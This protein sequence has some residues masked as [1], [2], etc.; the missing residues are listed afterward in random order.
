MVLSGRVC[1]QSLSSVEGGYRDCEGNEV[2]AVKG[3]LSV[4]LAMELRPAL[5]EFTEALL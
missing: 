2:G 1:S 4:A 5:P 3:V